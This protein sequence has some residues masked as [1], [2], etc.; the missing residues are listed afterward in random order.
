MSATAT[1]LV[2]V[3]DDAGYD[4]AA[5]HLPDVQVRRVV[6]TGEWRPL[7]V[8]PQSDPSARRVG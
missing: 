3:H 1:G 2:V 7:P 6:S 8:R 5:R 4:L